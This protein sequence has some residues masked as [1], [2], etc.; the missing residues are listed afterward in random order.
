MEKEK[1]FVT[2][3]INVDLWKIFSDTI[4]ELVETMWRLHWRIHKTKYFVALTIILFVLTL[5]IGVLT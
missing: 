2:I 3:K 4:D 5:T 1:L